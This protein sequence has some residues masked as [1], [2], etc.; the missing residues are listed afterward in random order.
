MAEFN[1]QAWLNLEGV[2]ESMAARCCHN[3]QAGSLRYGG[4]AETGALLKLYPGWGES[5]E[6]GKCA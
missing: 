6:R 5:T 1:R 2:R 4:G 3:P